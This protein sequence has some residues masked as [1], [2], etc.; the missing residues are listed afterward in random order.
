MIKKKKKKLVRRNATGQPKQA[1]QVA[2][3]DAYDVLVVAAQINQEAVIIL[4]ED[5]YEEANDD[6]ADLK[7]VDISIE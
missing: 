3:D 6:S 1:K 5:K 7:V 2:Q 4:T